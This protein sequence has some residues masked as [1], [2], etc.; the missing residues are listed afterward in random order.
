MGGPFGV[1]IHDGLTSDS[2][3]K[4]NEINADCLAPICGRLSNF[5]GSFFVEHVEL[6]A[7]FAALG[8]FP[9]DQ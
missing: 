5:L 8:A 9:S 7:V 2:A 6:F 3:D 1:R 4:S